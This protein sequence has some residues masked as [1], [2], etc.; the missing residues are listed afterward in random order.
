[1]SFVGAIVPPAPTVFSTMIVCFSARPIACPSMRATVSV[2]PPAANGTIST[3]GF[4]GYSC[5][6]AGTANAPT[7]VSAT[8]IPSFVLFMGF[9]GRKMEAD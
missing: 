1:M 6:A 4:D 9:S 8:I 3:M 7:A 5:A 2:G